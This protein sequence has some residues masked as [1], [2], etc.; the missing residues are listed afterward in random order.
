L[1]QVLASVRLVAVG[2]ILM[3][4]DVQRSAR[5]AAE[6]LPALWQ[7]VEPLLRGADIAFANLET[8]VAPSSGQ[9]GR[10]FQF[11]CPAELPAALRTSGFQVLATANNH[12]YDQGVAGVAETLAR[13]R[14]EGLVPVGSGTDRKDAETPRILD[15][16]GLRVAFLGF[17]DLFNNNLNQ[18]GRGPWVCPLD[19]DVAV[20]AVRQARLRAD[21][22]V[23]SVHWGVEYSHQPTPRQR[24][25]A[26]RLVAAGADLILGHHPHV[27]QPVEPLEQGG[28]RALVAFSMGN[29]VSNQ[30]RVYRADL[31][32]VAEGDSRDGVAVQC[33]LVKRRLADGSQAVS[34]EQSACE[35][36]WTL[37][38]WRDFQSGRAARR[39]IRVTPVGSAIRALQARLAQPEE[40]I[41]SREADQAFLRTLE[42]RRDRA[43]EV[44]GGA[45][46]P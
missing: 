16:R 34:V 18:A 22:V 14:A 23:V 13:L 46:R 9:P 40:P 12:A 11:N 30:D 20:Q 42:Q 21:A 39:E 8:P 27:L 31:L 6:G 41:A 5:E 3:H 26:A 2:D 33:T 7:D 24:E 29:F 36:L 45:A 37:N 17:T 25:V 1:P 43:L 35:P 32:P 44:L 15:V 19:P 28:R 4:Q 10:P 38:N